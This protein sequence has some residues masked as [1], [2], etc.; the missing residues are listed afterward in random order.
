MNIASREIIYWAFTLIGVISRCEEPSSQDVMYA[1]C[2]L[3]GILSANPDEPPVFYA[4]RLAHALRPMY[5]A[6]GIAYLRRGP[7]LVV[8]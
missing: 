2:F 1:N 5:G 6:P 8:D 3:A 4:Y 7:A